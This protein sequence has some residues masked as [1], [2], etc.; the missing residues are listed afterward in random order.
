[1]M[2]PRRRTSG[3]GLLAIAA[4]ASVVAAVAMDVLA[5]EH[6][7]HTAAAVIVAAV[8]AVLRLKTA[9]R[10]DGVL[11]AVGGALGAQ[12]A[13]HAIS[14]LGQPAGGHEHAGTLHVLASDGPV[15]AMQVA[16]PALVVVVAAFC[17]SLV[18]LLLGALRRP[19]R[20]L[21]F[22]PADE[23]HRILVTTR[24]IRHGSMLRWCGWAIRAARRGPPKPAF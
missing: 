1:M 20:S 3:S 14:K 4:V 10:C 7:S 6:P 17:A 13:L 18:L 15:I 19:V 22:A 8:V 16:V 2:G 21:I 5:D 9:S 12:P 24:T 11:S 23:S